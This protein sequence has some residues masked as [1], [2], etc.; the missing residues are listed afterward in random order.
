MAKKFKQPYFV[1]KHAVE[2]FQERIA[3]LSRN[4]IIEIILEALQEP[5]PIEGI[6][7]VYYGGMLWGKPLY[8]PVQIG[9]EQKDPNW[10]IVPTILSSESTLHRKIMSERRRRDEEARKRKNQGDPEISRN[11]R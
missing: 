3:S 1:T 2:Q 4:Q 8:I 10:P 11:D 6:H 7:G 5:K 9:L